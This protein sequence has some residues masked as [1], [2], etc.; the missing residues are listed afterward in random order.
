MQLSLQLVIYA[1]TERRRHR[2]SVS[3]VVLMG[4]GGWV[5]CA[6]GHVT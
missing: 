4:I 1:D 3:W 6:N 2:R 5:P